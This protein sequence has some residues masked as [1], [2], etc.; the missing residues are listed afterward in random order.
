MTV[1]EMIIQFPSVIVSAFTHSATTILA[2]NLGAENSERSRKTVYYSLIEML[3]V[4]AA[5]SLIVFLFSPWL[6][7]VFMS[8]TTADREL[9]YATSSSP[10][11]WYVPTFV[12]CG[13][14][15]I[16]AGLLRGFGRA[17]VAMLV[18]L[19]SIIVPR[20]LWIFFLFPLDAL[21]SLDGIYLCYPVS[22]AFCAVLLAVFLISTYKRNFP[23]KSL[24]C[25]SLRQSLGEKND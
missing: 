7:G 21:H 4:S 10:M 22:W 12:L 17:V 8:D 11:M 13:V 20:I 15:D 1:V 2:Q 18:C 24:D 16:L 6:L 3:M 19:P 25:E 5:I 9:V 23:K 14:M